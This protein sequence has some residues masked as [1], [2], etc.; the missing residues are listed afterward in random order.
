MEWVLLLYLVLGIAVFV[1][2]L[3]ATAYQLL[4]GPS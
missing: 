4:V 2:I 1:L 3:G